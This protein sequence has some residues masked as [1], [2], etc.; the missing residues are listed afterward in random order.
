[1]WTIISILV[2]SLIY[3]II[4]SYKK[5]KK[6]IKPEMGQ[7]WVKNETDPFRE[8]K[9]AEIIDIRKNGAGDVYVKVR[10]RFGDDLRDGGYDDSWEF[11]F[12]RL[13]YSLL[14]KENNFK[15]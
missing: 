10:Y 4:H 5:K 6:E 9:V 7:L 15:D 14:K 8:R 2:V 12:F 3:F 11:E 1:M 13:T